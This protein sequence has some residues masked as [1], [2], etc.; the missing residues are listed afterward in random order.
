MISAINPSPTVGPSNEQLFTVL[1]NFAGLLSVSPTLIVARPDQNA[2][3]V[4]MTLVGSNFVDGAVMFLDAAELPTT[5]Q[6]STTLF[7]EIPAAL[8]EDGGAREITVTN[9]APVVPRVPVSETLPT[10]VLNPVPVLESVIIAPVFF[11]DNLPNTLSGDPQSFESVFIFNGANWNGS[12]TFIFDSPAACELE[13][14]GGVQVLDSRQ[15]RATF[16][17]EC[18]GARTFTVQNE[19]INRAA[20]SPIPSP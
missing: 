7:A 19:T 14:G 13:E 5:F 15:G 3:P 6:S 8:L 9:P 17:I 11:D 2:Q 12:T 18:N 4:S 1:N 20:E 16:P 10:M